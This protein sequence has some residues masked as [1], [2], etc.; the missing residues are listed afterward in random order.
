MKVKGTR[1]FLLTSESGCK[2][3]ICYI[4][5]EIDE[6]KLKNS[7]TNNIISHEKAG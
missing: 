6:M 1:V 3:E 2:D 5:K 7:E 4:M